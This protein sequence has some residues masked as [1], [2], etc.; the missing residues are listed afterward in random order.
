MSDEPKNMWKKSFRGRTALVVWLAAAVFAVMLAGLMCSSAFPSW[1]GSDLLLYTGLVA[2][3]ILAAILV[4]VYVVWPLLRWLV[5]KQWRRT[6]FVLACFAALIVLFCLEEDW[7]GWRTW[8]HFQ[9]TWEAKGERFDR[10]SVVPPGVPDDQNFALTPIVASTYACWIDRTGHDVQPR[11]TN[12]VSRL[13]FDV[14]DLSRTNLATGSWAKSTLT[15]FRPLQA[16]Y[17]ALAAKTNLF[18]ATPRPQSPAADVL[19]ALSKF[20][21]RVEELRAAGH[22]PESRFPLE[23]DRE[24]PAAMLLPHLASLKSTAQLL[25]LRALAELQNGESQKALADARLLVRVAES[26]RTEPILISQ[27]VRIAILQTALQPVYEGLAGHRWSDA[28]LAELDAL[29]APVDFLTGYRTAMRG[30]I[31][32]MQIGSIQYQRRHPERMF[33]WDDAERGKPAAAAQLLRLIPSGW[34]YQNQYRCVRTMD[35]YFLPAVD[36]RQRTVSP[37][38][39]REAEQ[40]LEAETS[41]TTPYNVMEKMLI[42]ALSKA[43]MKFGYAQSA[44]DLARTAVALERYRLAH[45]SL[46]ESLDALV[47]QFMPSVPR[48]VIGGGPLKYRR[49]ADGQF[50]LYSIG[51]NATD[52]GGT[53]VCHKTFAKPD[54]AQGDWVW[55]YPAI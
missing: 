7:R 15:D 19:L 8:S 53:V 21:S 5:W 42:P 39:V 33:T 14:G 27:L 17:R 1:S 45:G 52:D 30:E 2:L 11:N 48:D 46:P 32:F 38:L 3:G 47:P 12:V 16:Y 35:E 4:S 26:V 44:T 29:L 34:Y 9:R 55:K 54:T 20:D 37:A 50:V 22:L 31:V 49:E 24:L 43:A 6:L 40:V 28:Q 23:Y 13:Q 18:P 41:R 10:A 51:W 36:A 25:Q